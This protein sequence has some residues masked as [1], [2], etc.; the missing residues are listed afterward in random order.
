EG[1][2]SLYRSLRAMPHGKSDLG[3][4]RGS[5]TA[6]ACS[7]RIRRA[8]LRSADVN[9]PSL[10]RVRARAIASIDLS[11]SSAPRGARSGGKA[12]PAKKAKK[13]KREFRT[14]KT[15]AAKE[16]KEVDLAAAKVRALEGLAHLGK[17][18]FTTGPGGY[19]LKHWLK[20]LN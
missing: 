16:D 18:Q 14:S 10:N 8:G 12:A 7:H 19:D 2:D 6:V 20:S 9:H 15:R 4:L 13:Q 17:Q 3:R 5:M 1:P 11:F